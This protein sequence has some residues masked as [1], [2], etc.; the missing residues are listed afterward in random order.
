MRV[1]GTPGTRA[2]TS[3][4][5]TRGHNQLK[6]AMDKNYDMVSQIHEITRIGE[7]SAHY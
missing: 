2:N 7:T 4:E 5:D 1:P 3:P 6:A